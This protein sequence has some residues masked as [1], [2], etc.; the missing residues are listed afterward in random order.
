[1]QNG[2]V[3]KEHK[4]QIEARKR[5]KAKNGTLRTEIVDKEDND[6]REKRAWTEEREISF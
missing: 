4:R 1:M 2:Q 5:R 6:E 3:Q